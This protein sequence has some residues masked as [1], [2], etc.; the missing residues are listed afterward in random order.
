MHVRRSDIVIGVLVVVGFVAMLRLGARPGGG[1]RASSPP[2]AGP[3]APAP[4]PG[5]EPAAAPGEISVLT[6]LREMVDLDALARLPP[7]RFVAGQAAS[8]DRRSRRPEDAE[9][10]FA[11]DDFVTDSQPNLVRVET[12]PDGGKR[13]VLL[14]ARGPGAIVRIW[15]ANPAGT[16]RIYLD[17]R[18]QPAVEAPFASLLRGEVA[19]FVAP[20]AHVTARGYN[21]YFPI[22]YR[23]RCVVTVDSIVSPDPFDGH[24]RAMLYYQIGTRT[25]PPAAAA[26]VRPYE[27]AE[28]ARA[29]GVLGRVAAVLRDGLPP[30]MPR[31][32]RSIVEIPAKTISAGRPATRMLVAPPGGGQIAELRLVAGERAAEKL[33]A[34]SLSITF[35]GEET[36]RAPLLAFFGTGGGFGAYTSLPMSVG[37]DGTLVCRFRMPFAERAIVTVAHDGPGLTLGGRM[38]IDAV[39]FGPDALL[40]HAGWHP[41]ELLATRPLRDWH[42]GTLEGVGQ[43]VG[44]LL[45]VDNPPGAAWWGEG[46]EKITVDGEP[47]P[48]W[49]GTGT[50]DYF[51]YAW[52]TPETF[53]HAYHAQT[54][55]PGDGFGGWFSMNRFHVLDPIP[56]VRSLRF[57]LELWHWSDTSIAAD[58]LLYWYAR[59]G[60]RDDFPRERR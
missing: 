46:D 45:D 48:S 59:P 52:S 39:P 51:G 16:L 56:F 15:S 27:V 18:S 32:G 55:A 28:V 33:A 3:L 2:P 1:R 30:A 42:L 6:L 12:A 19:P 31:P 17:D 54:R 47:F 24:P 25:Y 36:V 13:Y 5:P 9:G 34:T 57:D 7:E 41:R 29:T 53:T 10:W 43:L 8:T 38:A 20:L 60:G 23:R 21:L 14:D 49:F 50:E 44:T 35:D 22:P 11:N 4:P 40:F 37:E 26:E 58:A